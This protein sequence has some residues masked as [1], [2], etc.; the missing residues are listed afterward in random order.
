MVPRIAQGGILSNATLIA[1]CLLSMMPMVVH[2]QDRFLGIM[3]LALHAPP[4]HLIHSIC[5][6]F[7]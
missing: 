4:Q 6:P 5:I 1:V 3:C 2:D 7:A